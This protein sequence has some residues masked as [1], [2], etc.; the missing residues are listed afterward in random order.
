LAT[1]LLPT[2]YHGSVLEEILKRRGVEWRGDNY[3]YEKDCEIIAS[4]E[5]DEEFEYLDENIP[6]SDDDD[7]DDDDDEDDEGEEGDEKKE[8]EEETMGDVSFSVEKK[9][10]ETSSSRGGVTTSS[11]S[12]VGSHDDDD[13]SSRYLEDGRIVMK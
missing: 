1:I 10:N 3:D 11:P 8:E 5:L 9:A 12:T 7:D 6:T 2:E 4:S 13:F